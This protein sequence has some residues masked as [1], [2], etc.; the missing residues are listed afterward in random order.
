M[1]RTSKDHRFTEAQV[2]EAVRPVL[3]ELIKA[4]DKETARRLAEQR[5]EHFQ[6]LLRLIPAFNE[7]VQENEQL[8]QAFLGA[9]DYGIGLSHAQGKGRR[10]RMDRK[11]GR[12]KLVKQAIETNLIDPQ[13][14]DFEKLRAF[15]GQED[16]TLLHGRNG[17][18]MSGESLWRQFRRSRIGLDLLQ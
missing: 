17:R 2:L 15:I 6:E 9:L 1:P 8:R 4:K 12:C 11:Q 13:A 16:A 3:A 5:E 18:M 10:A 14:P 7:M